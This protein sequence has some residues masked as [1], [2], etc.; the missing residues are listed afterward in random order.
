[1]FVLGYIYKQ[2]IIDFVHLR[3]SKEKTNHK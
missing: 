1:L 2:R 3:F